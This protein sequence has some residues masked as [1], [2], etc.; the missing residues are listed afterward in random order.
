MSAIDVWTILTV[1]V[2]PF[3]IGA[4][5]YTSQTI[6]NWSV[7]P[8]KYRLSVFMGLVVPLSLLAAGF[9]A[10]MFVRQIDRSSEYT[11]CVTHGNARDPM[12]ACD[13]EWV[14]VLQGR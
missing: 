3:W 10:A 8:G 14:E 11:R 2:L 5:T 13:V 12:N 7:K 9:P 1:L 4:F 6:L